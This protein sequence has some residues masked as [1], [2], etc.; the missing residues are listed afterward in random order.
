MHHNS[1][2]KHPK[3]KIM[4]KTFLALCLSLVSLLAPAQTFDSIYDECKAAKGSMQVNLSKEMLQL[5]SAMQKNNV[6][7]S[8]LK[9]ADGMRIVVVR[10]PDA[11]LQ[12]KVTADVE[13][14][15]K[16]DGYTK[17][18]AR[19]Q[20]NKN[21]LNI[22]LIRAEGEDTLTPVITECVILM[23]G[24]ESENGKQTLL[25]AQA[26]GHFDVDDLEAIIKILHSR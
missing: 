7:N 13:A 18:M 11:K 9:K 16:P 10:N 4:K 8:I 5:A 20:K 1:Q 23:V 26:L 3:D 14:L 2:K 12:E 21:A 15:E 17:V 25:L 6:Q 19:E 22:T 24:S